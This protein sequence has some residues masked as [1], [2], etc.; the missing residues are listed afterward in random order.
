MMVECR[1]TGI[2]PPSPRMSPL[3]LDPSQSYDTCLPGTQ[4][5][6]QG[7]LLWFHNILSDLWRT[8]DPIRMTLVSFPSTAASS[9]SS[10]RAL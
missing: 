1:N 10:Q 8:E 5:S 7:T 9:P 2:N 4:T 6:S 3:Q